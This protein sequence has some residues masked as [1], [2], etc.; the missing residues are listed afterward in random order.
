MASKLSVAL[1]CVFVATLPLTAQDKLYP[2]RAKKELPGVP[3]LVSSDRLSFVI[4]KSFQHKITLGFP[5]D[6]RMDYLP[7]TRAQVVVLWLRIQNVSRNPLELDAAK[8]KSTDDS[9]RMFSSL[10]PQDATDRIMAGLSGSSIGTKALRRVSLGRAGHK[11]TVD[12]VREDILRYSLKSGEIAAGGV[13]EGFIFFEAPPRKKYVLNVSLGDLWSQP[14][15][16]S[17]EKQK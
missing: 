2:V 17:R 13:K 1:F 16:F 3:I 5:S 11:P 10:A 7:E 6:D 14:L 9:G 15:V 8:F 4:E 12:E